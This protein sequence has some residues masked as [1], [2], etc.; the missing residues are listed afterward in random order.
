MITLDLLMPNMDGKEV[1]KRL[2][3]DLEL[4]RIPV[5]IVTA[6]RD[7]D[8]EGIKKA[9]PLVSKPLDRANLAY[10]LKRGFGLGTCAHR[11]G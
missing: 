10:A 5:V 7:G 3:A 2:E 11:R 4:R 6:L 9:L 8:T 1:L